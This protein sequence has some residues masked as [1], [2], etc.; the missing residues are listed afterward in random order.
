MEVADQWRRE[1]AGTA[2]YGKVTEGGVTRRIARAME[3]L[4][5]SGPG[6]RVRV[7][8]AAYHSSAAPGAPAASFMLHSSR[9]VISSGYNLLESP[10]SP[11]KPLEISSTP[12]DSSPEPHTEVENYKVTEPDDFEISEPSKWRGSTK[13]SSIR[14]P[15]EESS[16]TDNASIIDLDSRLGR[17]LHRKYSYD[18][19]NSELQFSSRNTS[20]NSP[21]LDTPV[22]LSTLKY[23]SLL[24]SSNDWNSRRKSYS[25]EDTSPLNETITHSNDTLAMESSTDSGICKSTEVVNDQM[26]DNSHTRYL[27]R[28]D[29]KTTSNE[30][31][32]KDW[33]S[34]NRPTSHY[35]GTKF[36]TYREHDI[37]MEDPSENNITVQ[38]SG[39]V[40]INL[41]ITL[42]AD[43]EEYPKK[44][45]L[46]EEGDRRVKKVEFC[47]TEVH[48]AAES[49][50]VNIIATDEKPPPSND[51]RKRRSAF[52]PMQDMMEKPMITLFGDKNDFSSINGVGA[53]LNASGSE[54][55]ESDENTAATKS[56]LKN[57]IPKP[58]PYLLGENMAFGMSDDVMNND[59]SNDSVLSAVSL[60]NKQLKSENYYKPEVKPMYP[61]E[62]DD[63]IQ[64][65]TALRT[66]K[67][68]PTKEDSLKREKKVVANIKISKTTESC[69]EDVKS[70]FNRLHVT[71]S[72]RKPKTRQLRDSELT[73]FGVDNSTKTNSYK[74]KTQSKSSLGRND[75]VLENIFQSV[76]LIQQVAN[77]VCSEPDSDE[78][79]EYQNIP[80][81][82]N[83]APVPTPRVRTNYEDKPK[84]EIHEIQVFQPVIEKESQVVK[85]V[86][87]RRTRY[88]R[89]DEV[90]TTRSI[91]APPKSLRR[92]AVENSDQ[93][94]H[95]S[96][97]TSSRSIKEKKNSVEKLNSTNERNSS[98]EN[99]IYVNLNVN[100]E[101]RNSLENRDIKKLNTNSLNTRQRKTHKTDTSRN[102]NESV[103][104]VLSDLS[105]SKIKERRSDS[106]TDSSLRTKDS[107]NKDS[108]SRS[109]YKDSLS[110]R[111]EKS[112]RIRQAGDYK[113]KLH[114]EHNTSERVRKSREDKFP[115]EHKSIMENKDHRSKS[116]Q[117]PSSK[118]SEETSRDL[119]KKS[120][121]PKSSLD[122][123]HGGD[124]S[125][126]RNS[127]RDKSTK[128]SIKPS[129]KDDLSYTVLIPSI[130]SKNNTKD[131]STKTNSKTRDSRRKYVINYDDKNGTVSSICKITPSLGTPKRKK[132]TK[133]IFRDGQNDKTFKNNNVHKIA[134]RK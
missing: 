89:Q 88:R 1:W 119:V 58:K 130:Q 97:R 74:N 115:K 132:T 6:A 83:Y 30:E 80:L 22:T 78:T 41:P 68:G 75:D 56:I 25:F 62:T 113:G 71:P 73:Y 106:G 86:T 91:S 27:Y 24:N 98:D 29:R 104:N 33:L 79:P 46:N 59:A 9:R 61:R 11:I 38:S 93:R 109:A 116:L 4:H 57:K 64:K 7:M 67:A 77:S 19:E 65:P 117:R 3:V 110:R 90:T 100:I 95:Q 99:P 70:K 40:C 32:F 118:V 60:V 134:P 39:K 12:F 63:S 13:G 82:M 69:I 94:E 17:N 55:G 85:D 103:I 66:T 37:V 52:V 92:D 35:R 28:E 21:L 96:P 125:R 34:K 131:Y 23:K 54:F 122:R 5:A 123:I 108:Y 129:Q 107:G 87:T 105:K 49:G 50:K 31:S 51:F 20:R 76:K 2:E 36:K 44:H 133:E 120:D 15:S 53:P 47:K 128:E 114:E 112:D 124:S 42:E 102:K 43:S 111:A 48:F 81:N 8:R 127:S 126:K 26:D 10:S 45:Q 121:H 18:S 84:E 101:K 14:M 72:Q 16:S